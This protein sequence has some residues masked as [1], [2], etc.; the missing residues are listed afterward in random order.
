[1]FYFCFFAWLQFV[2]ALLTGL[3]IGLL[4]AIS[5]KN[6][7]E[8]AGWFLLTPAIGVTIY[9]AFGTT[10]H[11]A[12]LGSEHAFA[13]LVVM[14]IVVASFWQDDLAR[15][16]LWP[17]ALTLLGAALVISLNV[18]DL[19]FA[20]L[21]Y[22]PL[23]NDDTF[24]YIGLIDQ[25]REAGWVRPT[26]SYPAGFQPNIVAAVDARAPGAIWIAD[27]AQALGLNTHTAFFVTQ[28]MFLPATALGATG[29][30][31]LV[32]GSVW[33]ACLC[34]VSLIF[35]NTLL[36][37]MLQ[38]FNSSA[39]GTI[40]GTVVLA[41][42]VWSGR[43]ERSPREAA[44]GYGLAGFA[45]G[46][47]A[48]TSMEAHPFYLGIS[49]LILVASLVTNNIRGRDFAKFVLVFV[50]GYLAP[51][52][53]FLLKVWPQIVGQYFLAPAMAAQAIAVPGFL[54]FLSGVSL[55]VLPRLLNYP[56]E[57]RLVAVGAV[58]V[59]LAS[60]AYLLWWSIRK[61]DA[62][63]LRRHD[64]LVVALFT[65]SVFSMEIFLYCAGI[66]YGLLKMADYFAFLNAVAVSIV[67]VQMAPRG[68]LWKYSAV[69][70]V[71]L[72]CVFAYFGKVDMLSTY[73]DETVKGRLPSAYRGDPSTTGIDP[74]K[75]TMEQFNLYLYEN[76]MDPTQIQI[77]P[78]RSFRFRSLE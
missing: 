74:T 72:F 1:M 68:M 8:G 3:P 75:L 69:C 50:V 40:V 21:D 32:T 26:I 7:R 16:A 33:G 67:A 51:S 22:F 27:F 10:L 29:V 11:F 37:Q 36:H 15:R 66:G 58:L 43:T 65:A 63:T 5:T 35:G 52:I 60:C 41:M 19:T 49:G 54:I 73:R 28:R 12:G 14:P 71:G 6:K 62:S 57:I 30:V 25:I 18:R 77:P 17:I 39:M 23:T 76:R 34:L 45:V 48:I 61:T 55:R 64:A 70:L 59:S 2:V 53:F 44:I 47:M 24:S 78:G 9:L 38:Q 13:L 42:L 20:G 4:L 31:L 46:T 56:L